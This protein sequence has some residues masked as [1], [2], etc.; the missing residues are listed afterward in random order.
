[1]AGGCSAVFVTLRLGRGLMVYDA[2]Y[3]IQNTVYNIGMDRE[4][5][6][7]ASA[8]KDGCVRSQDLAERLGISRQYAQRILRDLVRHGLLRK[9]GST[10][11]ASYVLPGFAGPVEWTF[12]KRYKNQHL[13]EHEVLGVI[14]RSAPFYPSLPENVRSI[15]AYAF[16]EMLNNAIEHSQSDNVYI[17]VEKRSQS[18]SFH[19]GDGGI[20]V[21]RNIMRQR[22][23]SSE[24]DAV[25]D[26]LKG[27]TTTAPRAHSGEGIFFTSRIADIFA[28]E[29]FGYK[30]I[31]DHLVNDIFFEVVHPSKRGTK[32]FF[33]MACDGKKNLAD[34]FRAHQTDPHEYAFDKTTIQ[35][36]LYAL[37]AEHISRSQARRIVA[38]LE[39][40]RSIVLDF[41]RVP[42]IGQAFADEIFRVFQSAH[43]T[44]R[45]TPIHMNDAVRFMVGR[46]GK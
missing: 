12:R 3:N 13:A 43:P 6:I 2:V 39:K 25:Q 15:F 45:I 19:V 4:D 44:I 14:E 9:I 30:L 24:L 11:G 41:D 35:V 1:M 16:S 7:L 20:G 26:L 42:Q 23:L 34:I 21:F 10:R 29:S 18:L 5:I 40:F 38:G 22:R 28:L 32:V 36:R 27:K 8:R 17:T 37:G 33:Q 46:V 31:M